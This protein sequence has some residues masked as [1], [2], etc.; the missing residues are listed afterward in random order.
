MSSGMQGNFVQL[1]HTREPR[2][3]I[4]GVMLQRSYLILQIVL[5]SKVTTREKEH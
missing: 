2:K 5:L 3:R 4:L 1:E